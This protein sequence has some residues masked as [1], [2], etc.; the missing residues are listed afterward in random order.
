MNRLT[1]SPN[2]R[3]VGL[4]L[5]VTASLIGG[6]ACAPETSPTPVPSDS[7][8]NAPF[9]RNLPSCA[10]RAEAIGKTVTLKLDIK[11]A[12]APGV[13]DAGDVEYDYGDDHS[14]SEVGHTY[15]N[16]GSYTVRAY[17]EMDVA[18]G[19]NVAAPFKDGAM[20]SCSPVTVTIR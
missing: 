15:A 7:T 16:A 4:P 9:F 14:G 20:V 6:A 2:V 18:P 3:R 10:L 19:G 12:Y 13:Y 5:A 8:L 1:Y 11:D 17:M